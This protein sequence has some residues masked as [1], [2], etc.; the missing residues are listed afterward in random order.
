MLK[1]GSEYL[2]VTATMDYQ[3]TFMGSNEQFI[4]LSHPE[5]GAHIADMTDSQY[6]I[7]NDS[8]LVAL[9][10]IQNITEVR[11]VK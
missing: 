2:V 10:E 5:W 6:E 1:I 7:V 4:K 9:S 3:G 8:Y 11:K